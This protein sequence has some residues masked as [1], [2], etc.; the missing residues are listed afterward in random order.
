[1]PR[2]KNQTKTSGPSRTQS[3]DKPEEEFESVEVDGGE[4][5]FHESPHN[6]P[7]KTHK[8]DTI[9]ET[10]KIESNPAKQEDNKLA[11]DLPKSDKAETSSTTK[12]ETQKESN[13][14]TLNDSNLQVESKDSKEKGKEEAS[15][16]SESSYIKTKTA[17]EKKEPAKEIAKTESKEETLVNK[18]NKV[19]EKLEADEKVVVKEEKMQEK[20]TKVEELVAN[21]GNSQEKLATPVE[22]VEERNAN[23]EACNYE[24]EQGNEKLVKF[25]QIDAFEQRVQRYAQFIA[26]IYGVELLIVSTKHAVSIILQ[27]ERKVASFLG[28]ESQLECLQGKLAASTNS[29]VSKTTNKYRQ[30]LKESFLTSTVNNVCYLGN[31]TALSV[32]IMSFAVYVNAYLPSKTFVVSISEPSVNLILS[33]ATLSKGIIQRLSAD[34]TK[35]VTSLLKGLGVELKTLIKIDTTDEEHVRIY[36]NKQLLNAAPWLYLKIKLIVENTTNCAKELTVEAY[37]SSANKIK[38]IRDFAMQE[39]RRFLVAEKV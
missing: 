1:M 8:T 30:W 23:L 34:I 36:I 4:N 3:I 22:N 26:S 25:E 27:F 17:T 32:E 18:E 15:V 6:S 24:N 38:L 16:T 9:N 10:S 5:F 2:N 39:Y 31:I 21:D 12:E 37:E 13:D 28:L 14:D 20:E 29:V 7:T 11:T 19:E 35:Q 33:T